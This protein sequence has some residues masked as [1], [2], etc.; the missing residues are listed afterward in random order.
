MLAKLHASCIS[1][2]TRL[3][4]TSSHLCMNLRSLEMRNS[5]K[6][7]S[8]LANRITLRALEAFSKEEETSP[9]VAMRVK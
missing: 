1:V 4:L 8:S 2:N 7:L 9:L 5:F 3:Q 6:R